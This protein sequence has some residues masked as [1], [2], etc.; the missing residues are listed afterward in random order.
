MRVDGA[1]RKIANAVLYE[2][3]LL[4]PYTAS[5]P[6]NR[7]RWQFGVLV[8]RAYAERGGGEPWSMQTELVLEPRGHPRVEIV[9]R[10]LQVQRRGVEAAAAGEFV[11][12]EELA[13]DGVIHHGWDEAVERELVW[14]G[15]L[16]PGEY[17]AREIALDG[18]RESEPV[19][20]A[21]GAVRGRFVRTCW[22]LRGTVSIA[23][24]PLGERVK[25]RVRVE[26]HSEPTAAGPVRAA[27]RSILLRSAFVSTHTLLA[28]EEGAFLST[29]D[30]PHA[31]AGAVAACEN[32][33]T[34]PVLIASLDIRPTERSAHAAA[35]VL[36]SPI[37]LYDYPEVAAE[38]Q[39]DAFD[40][41]E[42]DELL[43]LTVA[44]MSDAEKRAARATD[45]RARGIVDRAEQMSP[46]A[47]ARLHATM[48][49]VTPAGEETP[50]SG[51]IVIDGRRIAKGSRVRLRPR[52]R[53]DV[54]DMFLAGRT[55][56]VAGVH[57]DVDD[58]RYVAVTVDDDPASDVHDWY[59]RYWYFA[60]EEIEPLEGEG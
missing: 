29:L 7:S 15:P 28:V 48:R 8:P 41:T 3:Y 33:N 18:S 21:G 2:G 46:E 58:R 50:G 10:F 31:A 37:I 4:Y 5:T 54:W 34:F 32:R 47:F 53:A 14:S 45:G 57:E 56:R 26:N 20:D 24:E 60:P 23:S 39:G 1:V 51:C 25:L 38:S 12:V 49:P 17:V 13:V 30:P 35:A 40:A 52:R 44:S 11:P 16:V 19:R 55:A 42:I 59:G 27:E 6:K 22:P 43:Y 36:S 9:V